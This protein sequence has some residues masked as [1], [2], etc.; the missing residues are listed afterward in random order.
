MGHRV[1]E[2][3]DGLLAAVGMI[4]NNQSGDLAPSGN[5]SE[6]HAAS[7]A[8]GA[9]ERGGLHPEH[10]QQSKFA[11]L[12]LAAA[13]APA[14]DDDGASSTDSEYDDEEEEPAYASVSAKAGGKR[15]GGASKSVPATKRS[16]AS[17]VHSVSCESCIVKKNSGGVSDVSQ[18]HHPPCSP[19]PLRPSPAATTNAT[20]TKSEIG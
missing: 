10:R 14:D 20:R 4:R 8:M 17:R 5:R 3:L 15:A 9:S 6:R 7:S 1:M 18:P 19:P 12:A 11:A 2:G 13:D 16:K